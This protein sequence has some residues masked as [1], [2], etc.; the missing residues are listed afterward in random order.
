[1]KP[2]IYIIGGLLAFGLLLGLG[3]A[4]SWF[5]LVTQRP[6]GQY[7]EDTR[8]LTFE[9]SRAHQSGVNSAISDYCLNLRGATDPAQK[10][11]LARWI[12]NEAATFE[13]RLTPDADACL[14]DARAAL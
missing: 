8:R 13:G 12:I 1:M 11:A 3:L 4:T 10:Q 6:M 9:R 5:G 7:A 2:V 14:A